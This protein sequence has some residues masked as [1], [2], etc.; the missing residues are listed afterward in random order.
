MSN[1]V[2][3]SILIDGVRL[4]DTQFTRIFLSQ[5]IG[6]HHTLEVRLRQDAN[7]GVLAQKAK[8]WIGKSIQI[9][10]GFQS[11][12]Q[13]IKV[14]IPDVFI[15][16]ISS[17]S[18]LRKSGTAELVLQG[19]SPTLFFDDGVHTR[20]FTDKSLQE[21]VDEALMPYKKVFAEEPRVEPK[22]FKD[23]L[24]YTVQYKESHFAFIARLANRYGEWCYYDG[25]QFFFG[26]PDAEPE[27]KLDFSHEGLIEFDIAVQAI[28]AK[29]EMRGYDY[30]VH[31]LL[32]EEA[33]QTSPV[34][35]LGQEVLDIANNHI[36]PL[37]NSTLVNVAM[38]QGEMEQ[39][40]QRTEQILLDEMVVLSGSSQN[41]KLKIG[42][43][44]SLRDVELGENYGKYVITNLSHEIGQG[45]AYVNYFEAIPKEVA[46]PPLSTL[47]EPPFC[48]TQLATVT[49]VDDKDRLGRVKVK[50][51]WQEG[52]EEKSP[53]IRVA[54]SYSGKDKGF[55]VIPEVGDQVLVA[56]ENN[57]P[58]SPYVLTGMYN[59]EAKPE[60]FDEGN[61]Y[62]GFKSK[63]QNQ[64]KFDDKEKSI[65]ISAPSS[66]TLSADDS[67][68]L[69]TSGNKS[70][71]IKLDA[72]D[73]AIE[74]HAKT[75][76]IVTQDT[77]IKADKNVS[78]KG[79]LIEIN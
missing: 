2:R 35:S 26:K 43:T 39:L 29:F 42:A 17:V 40:V 78:I 75:V 30:K 61:R 76:R 50:F 79:A 56:F 62:K 48:E 41:P 49:E 3:A 24:P 55:Y 65:T 16:V 31:K 8:E 53:W 18:L 4:K 37:T 34:N 66:I 72:G 38:N 15:G 14:P 10:F 74:V 64:W 27:I 70:S 69:K 67:I 63:G 68:T 11:E 45:G 57:H 1:V 46:T 59:G 77:S 47:S 73:G 22:Q 36:Y 60:W 33:A 20:S 19:K 21:I 13:L 5:N 12:R 54:S 51:L 6:W 71:N 23:I 9:G 58:A 28:P 32:K 7:K 44:V 25:L 52:S